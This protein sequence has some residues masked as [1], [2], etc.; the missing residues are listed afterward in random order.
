RP[1]I[2]SYFTPS[3]AS[4]AEPGRSE[5]VLAVNVFASVAIPTVIVSRSSSR[6][7][8]QR[9][10]TAPAGSGNGRSVSVALVPTDG[11]SPGSQAATT[12]VAISVQENSDGRYG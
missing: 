7:T 1:V 2:A 11:S 3:A 6:V 10:S 9:P 5:R 12:I 8:Y 4:V